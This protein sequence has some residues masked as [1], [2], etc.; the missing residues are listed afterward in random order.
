MSTDGEVANA[1]VCK[2]SIHGFKSHSVLQ[3]F[4]RRGL[5]SS[6]LINLKVF[7]SV[8]VDGSSSHRACLPTFA[9]TLHLGLRSFVDG[10]SVCGQKFFARLLAKI[11]HFAFPIRLA[12]NQRLPP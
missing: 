4:E 6:S 9:L 2:T 3:L 10:E 1:L 5:I 11:Y 12:E 7:A 8:G